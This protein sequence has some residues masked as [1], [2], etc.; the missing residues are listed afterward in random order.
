MST[1]ALGTSEPP[2]TPAFLR[3]F[4]YVDLAVLA[5]AL[6][7]FVLASLPLLGY[8]ASALAW[9]AQRGIRALL[10]RQAAETDDPRTMVGLTAASMIA[11]GWLVAL[12]IFG[13]GMIEREAGLAAAVLAIVLFT[14]FLSSEM[15]LRPLGPASASKSARGS[16]RARESGKPR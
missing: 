14:A 6:P 8:A 13:A 1:H 11:R 15:V 3:A 10:E 9:L 4:R 7:I 12:T 5:L 16:G 2:G